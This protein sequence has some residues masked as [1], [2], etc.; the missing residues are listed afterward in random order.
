MLV[1]MR[2]HV[3]SANVSS[4]YLENIDQALD[5]LRFDKNEWP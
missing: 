2:S 5:N 1:D 3:N 4:D